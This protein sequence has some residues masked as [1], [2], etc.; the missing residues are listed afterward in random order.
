[1]QTGTSALSHSAYFHFKILCY[2]FHSA[3]VLSNLPECK[4][5]CSNSKNVFFYVSSPN[6][7][8]PF[9][10]QTNLHKWDVCVTNSSPSIHQNIVRSRCLTYNSFRRGFDGDDNGDDDNDGD[11]DGDDGDDDGDGDLPSI[12]AVGSVVTHVIPSAGNWLLHSLIWTNANCKKERRKLLWKTKM[13]PRRIF[14]EA[15]WNIKWSKRS[16]R[17][18]MK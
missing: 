15:R 2:F 17:F 12:R 1:M 18:M 11:D 4:H 13:A 14:G 16:W 6:L 3:S 7:V 8:F 5:I 9:F 10:L